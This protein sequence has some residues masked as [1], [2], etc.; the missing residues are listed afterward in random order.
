MKKIILF[1]RLRD[2]F[3]WSAW[4]RWASE[5]SITPNG[6]EITYE[7]DKLT[8]IVKYSPAV[9]GDLPGFNV[10]NQEAVNQAIMF[11]RNLKQTL[12][13]YKDDEELIAAIHFGGAIT[14]EQSSLKQWLEHLKKQNEEDA[15]FILQKFVSGDKV[16]LTHYSIGGNFRRDDE[17]IRV[18]SRQLES[19]YQEL[20]GEP[21]DPLLEA[22]LELLHACLTPE[23]LKTVIWGKDGEITITRDGQ[24]PFKGR[25][26]DNKGKVEFEAL[27]AKTDGPFGMEYMDTLAAL[28]DALLPEHE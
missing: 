24:E 8:L 21:A 23:G 9:L 26:P 27:K 14:F 4:C 3:E 17:F 2:T 1:T 7:Q 28:R 5:M 19:F 11:I 18:K 12:E 15:D 25:I 20:R 10:E 13:P 6:N 22:K 16:K